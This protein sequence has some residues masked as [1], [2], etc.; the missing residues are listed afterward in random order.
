MGVYLILISSAIWARCTMYLLITR[1]CNQSCKQAVPR[2]SCRAVGVAGAAKKATLLR[3]P[4]D[5]SKIN[6]KL[7][8]AAGQTSPTESFYIYNAKEASP[9]L[10]AVHTLC[11]KVNSLRA[12]TNCSTQCRSRSLHSLS[13]HKERETERKRMGN[14]EREILRESTYT[15][16]EY[17]PPSYSPFG[18]VYTHLA[19]L[20][21]L[22]V[23]TNSETL[24][25]HLS[26]TCI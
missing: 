10:A 23:C 4:R 1:T 16:R 25:R 5:V 19:A 20:C 14:R 2:A 6:A 24:L 3:R 21:E 26:C 15:S 7:N 8:Q 22:K 13:K 12:R 11:E 17:L 9:L 18:A